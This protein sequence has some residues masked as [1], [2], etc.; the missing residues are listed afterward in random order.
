MSLTIERIRLE[1]LR[2]L[3]DT[4]RNATRLAQELGHANPSYVSHMLK[5]RRP[6]TEKTA[7]RIE[8][9]L[10]LPRGWLDVP[11]HKTQRVAKTNAN[12]SSNAEEFDHDLY[13]RVAAA[14]SSAV[15]KAG[16]RIDQRQYIAIV[17]LACDFAFC[18][19]GVVDEEHIRKLL[20]VASE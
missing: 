8:E 20:R 16:T 19:N 3:I 9:K 7:R 17:E 13:A 1:N 6:L 2:G 10:N 15:A 4:H 12:S 18:S 14:V 5:G 11:Q